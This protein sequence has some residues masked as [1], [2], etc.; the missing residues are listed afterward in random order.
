M[1]KRRGCLRIIVLIRVQKPRHETISYKGQL[2]PG[3]SFG[4]ERRPFE[5]GWRAVGLCYP[6]YKYILGV[7]LHEQRENPFVLVNPSIL[8]LFV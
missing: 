2:G 4:G 3:S 5:W 6:I 7:V 1:P 8:L